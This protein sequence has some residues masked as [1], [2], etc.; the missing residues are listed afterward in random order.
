MALHTEKTPPAPPPLIDDAQARKALRRLRIVSER[1]WLRDG[2]QCD[3]SEYEDAGMHALLRCLERFDPT[4]GVQFATYAE[5]RI[6]GAVRDAWQRYQHWRDCRVKG[7]ERWS[8]D[9]DV[10][11]PVLPQVRETA[12]DLA[13]QMP[14]WPADLQRYAE[15]VLAGDLDQEYAA[16][17]GITAGAVVARKRRWQAVILAA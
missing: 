8:H 15:A 14:C 4:R 11:H 9:A 2:C 12:G 1:Q 7:L 10:V 5:H 17:E 3:L 16:Q 13:R 6:N